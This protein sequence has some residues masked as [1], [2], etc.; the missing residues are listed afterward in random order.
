MNRL[1]FGPLAMLD[2]IRQKTEEQSNQKVATAD[3]P[4]SATSPAES[5]LA[6]DRNQQGSTE[7]TPSGLASIL[8]Q[9][10]SVVHFNLFIPMNYEPN[11][12]Y[13]LIVYLHDRGQSESRI[14]Q[15]MPKLSC[16]NYA[17]ISVRSPGKLNSGGNDSNHPR[18]AWNQS[19]DVIEQAQAAVCYA[20]KN[21]MNRLNINPDRVFLVGEGD[22]GTMA[23]RLAFQNPEW[24]AGV[25]SLNGA[26]PSEGTP[27]S[28]LN[29]ARDV[30]VFWCHYR[31]SQLFPEDSLCD[32]LSLLHTA[33]FNL[34]LRQYPNDDTGC[35]QVYSDLNH[36]VMEQ[37]TGSAS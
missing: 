31:Q 12:S 22:G 14:H 32:G 25:A 5:L 27:F 20:I 10:S 13:P 36:W 15:T 29:I 19:D 30:P 16:R 4:T 33:G 28:R 9:S 21:A 34:T 11:Y 2:Q 8:D 37:V 17:A 6:T 1:Q 26:L 3:E 23:L 7:S 35:N 18:M 24:F